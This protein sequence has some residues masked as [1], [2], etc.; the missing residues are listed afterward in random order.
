MKE[1]VEGRGPSRDECES[2]GISFRPSVERDYEEDERI[3]ESS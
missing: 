3:E 2:M 1:K